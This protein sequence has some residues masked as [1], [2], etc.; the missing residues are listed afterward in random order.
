MPCEVI[1]VT[2]LIEF[3]NDSH[4][5]INLSN[6]LGSFIGWNLYL[7]IILHNESTIVGELNEFLIKIVHKC[8]HD[9]NTDC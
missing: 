1:R 2:V 8:L 5:L 7:E 9:D 3:V 4:S 6:F